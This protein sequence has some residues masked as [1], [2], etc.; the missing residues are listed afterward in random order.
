MSV[1]TWDDDRITESSALAFSR[2]WSDTAYT[3][4][5]EDGQAFTVRPSTGKTIGTFDARDISMGD[6]E[7]MSVDF[8]GTLWWA[9]LGDNDPSSRDWVNLYSRGE[10]GPG[11]K[12]S[13]K[14][15]HYRLKYP[16][17]HR[18][19]ECFLT[20]PDG[21]KYI[22]SKESSGSVYKLPATLQTGETFN[23]MTSVHGPDSAMDL[24][25]DGAFSNDGKWI[26]LVRK[27]QNSTIYVFNTS[28]SQVGTITMTTMSKPEGITVAANGKSLWVC[29]D[30]GGPGGKLQNVKIPGAW[31]PAGTTKYDDSTPATGAD[32]APAPPVNPCA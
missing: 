19:A 21:S 31:L 13:L 27:N 15:T 23:T 24:V 1:V 2:K 25:S 11:N 17:G 5:D 26:F 16:G 22:I 14:F 9:D 28:W 18:N 4:N 32:P 6:P 12:G 10:P 7:S 3:A 30:N 29:D 8:K 20:A